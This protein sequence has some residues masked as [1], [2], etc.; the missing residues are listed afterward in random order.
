[1]T[2]NRL[3]KTKLRINSVVIAAA[4]LL[5]AISLFFFSYS[6]VFPTHLAFAAT[7]VLDIKRQNVV[8]TINGPIDAV[9][10]TA[11]TE[12]I[13][14]RQFHLLLFDN[15]HVVISQT[16]SARLFDSEGKLIGESTARDITVS[17]N[18]G[19]PLHQG[20]SFTGTCTGASE[21]PGHPFKSHFSQ[22]IGKDGT[23][24][25]SK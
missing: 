14:V 16:L 21:N 3:K 19:L 6:F 18:Q 24:H 23:I 4:V 2:I 25:I 13:T 17:G 1:M 12:K 8:F 11:S 9:C 20:S 5:F 7:K 10:G 15:N 22:T